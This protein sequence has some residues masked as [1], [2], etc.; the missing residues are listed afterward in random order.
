MEK[1]IFDKALQV[2]SGISLEIETTFLAGGGREKLGATNREPGATIRVCFCQAVL[3][4]KGLKDVS[5]EDVKG[6]T[7]EMGGASCE[8]RKQREKK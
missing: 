8:D 1:P 2:I 3:A 7:A 6:R 4:V 5:L